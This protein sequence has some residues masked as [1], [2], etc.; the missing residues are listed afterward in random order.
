MSVRTQQAFH[1]YPF[2]CLSGFVLLR[3]NVQ[4]IV[5]QEEDEDNTADD[6][7]NDD[8]GVRSCLPRYWLQETVKQSQIRSLSRNRVIRALRSSAVK[9]MTLQGG[10]VSQCKECSEQA[11]SR[12]ATG[13]RSCTVHRQHL[14]EHDLKHTFMPQKRSSTWPGTCQAFRTWHF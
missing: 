14:D 9:Y 5:D 2:A 4:G 1:A 12:S 11:S 8:Y 10:E 3:K 13:P 7:Q 6:R